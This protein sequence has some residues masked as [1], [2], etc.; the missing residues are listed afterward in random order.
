MLGFL[1]AGFWGNTARGRSCPCNFYQESGVSSVAVK[2]SHRPLP[3]P[4]THNAI[5]LQPCRL[6]RQ[7]FCSLLYL[8][9]R[10][11]LH[12]HGLKASY[13]H[14]CWGSHY[15]PTLPAADLL[16]SCFQSTRKVT[17]CL[18]EV[19]YQLQTSQIK[20]LLCYP[21]CWTPLQ[22]DLNPFLVYPSLGTLPQP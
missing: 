5:P 13:L 4:W 3:Q 8:E 9:T 7:H 22:K 19:S 10:A 2:S 11:P 12:P 15:K 20:N 16:P 18:P 6:I 17:Y 21:V 14:L 1:T